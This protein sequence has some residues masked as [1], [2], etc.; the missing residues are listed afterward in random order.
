MGVVG[1]TGEKGGKRE[2]RERESVSKEGRR[3][4]RVER[5]CWSKNSQK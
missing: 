3:T 1:K 5:G 4:I 2:N